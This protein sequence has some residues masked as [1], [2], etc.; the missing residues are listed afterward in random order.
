MTSDSTAL[1][2][3]GDFAGA[4]AAW[5]DNPADSL[6][7]S[8]ELAE[9]EERWGDALFFAFPRAYAAAGCGRY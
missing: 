8:W 4:R 2:A 7:A 5:Q 1:M 9:I 6:A 3:A